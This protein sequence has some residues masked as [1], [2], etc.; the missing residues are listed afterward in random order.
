MRKNT[1][2]QGNVWN[3]TFDGM[4][5]PKRSGLAGLLLLLAAG[6]VFSQNAQDTAGSDS[7]VVEAKAIPPA[8]IIT[9]GE[10]ALRAL[11]GIESSLE[12][13]NPAPLISEKLTELVAETEPFSDETRN[14]LSANPSFDQLRLQE[15][16]WTSTSLYFIGWRK[17]LE[18][19]SGE[20]SAQ[21]TQL[22]LIT[23]TW[24]KTRQELSERTPELAQRIETVLSLADSLRPK[25]IARQ[26]ELLALESR[27][28]DEDSRVQDILASIR[29]AN[30]RAMGNLFVRDIPPVWSPQFRGSMG[31]SLSETGESWAKQSEAVKTYIVWQKGKIFGQILLTLLLVATLFIVRKKMREWAR[32]DADLKQAFQIFETPIAAAFLLGLNISG[33]LYPYA[34]NLWK[35]FLG[36][37]LLI[38]TMIILLRLVER[39]LFPVLNSLVVFYFLD[40]VRLLS[41]AQPTLLRLIFLLEVI[42]AILFLAWLLQSFKKKKGTEPDPIGRAVRIGGRLALALMTFALMAELAGFSRLGTLM[43]NGALQSSYVAVILYA[44]VLVIQALIMA[45]F[46]TP[47]LSRL[48]IVRQYRSLLLRRTFRLLNWIVFVLWLAIALGTFSLRAPVF[49]KLVAILAADHSFGSLTFSLFNLIAFGLTIWASFLVSRL[50]RFVLEHDIYPHFHL[51]HGVPYAISTMLHYSILFV[52]FFMATA[53]LGI[54]MTKFTILVSAFGVGVGFGLQNI[55]NNFVSGLI[56]LFERPVKIGDS[57]QVGDAVGTVRRIGIRA[58]VLRTSSGSEIIVPNGTLIS[59]QVTNWTL[60]RQR[61]IIVIPISVVRGPEPGHVM[62]VMKQE[63]AKHGAVLKEP[64]P[65][66]MI[67]GLAANLAFEL[68]VWTDEVENW[69]Q[70][71]SDLML[72]I[73]EALAKEDI[74]TA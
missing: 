26:K 35:G 20:C 24:E 22:N 73:S 33:M 38:P 53:A 67:T 58:S 60:S 69:I 62:E 40:Q 72:S 7:P 46:K 64:A 18:K 52:A 74:K 68:R 63:A 45:A 50:A 39:R 11:R 10:S 32:G 31:R 54:D 8:R 47:L 36:A 25:V 23:E 42:G 30:R 16:G 17:E 29:Q 37:M 65:R 19:Y 27:L 61:R 14:I 56:L 49:E 5:L 71:R 34:P 59:T 4:R 6:T 15:E 70:I 2:L 43:L 9:E 41:S 55:I 1:G 48:G 12:T 66:V 44:G 13:E 3:L 21:L 28:S 51:A 57:I